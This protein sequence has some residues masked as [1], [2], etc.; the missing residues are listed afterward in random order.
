M[1]EITFPLSF[2]DAIIVEHH[3]DSMPFTV[4]NLAI[5]G[6]SFVLLQLEIVSQVECFCIYESGFG[7]VLFKIV[8][9][10]FEGEVFW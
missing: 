10:R 7:L 2:I 3:S 5:V 4:D 9:E 1:F 6:C 8:D